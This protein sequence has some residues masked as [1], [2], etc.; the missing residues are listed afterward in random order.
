[1][2]KKKNKTKRGGNIKLCRK[3]ALAKGADMKKKKNKTKRGGRLSF[4]VWH[5]ENL[6]PTNT[7][8]AMNCGPKRE[9]VLNIY[10]I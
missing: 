2:K 3:S 10:T 7:I 1:M 4:L 8:Y 6:K 9:P 5:P